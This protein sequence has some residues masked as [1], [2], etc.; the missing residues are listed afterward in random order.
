MDARQITPSADDDIQ[1]IPM[2][3]LFAMWPCSLLVSTPRGVSELA[4]SLDLAVAARLKRK[5]VR[6]AAIHLHEL[7]VAAD[8]D[9]VALVQYGDLIRHAHGREPG[10]KSG[11]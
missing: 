4:G 3:T 5:Q 11:W 8:F 7:F 9:D 2:A 6:V 10:A 1:F